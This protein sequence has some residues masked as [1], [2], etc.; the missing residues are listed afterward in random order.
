MAE[1]KTLQ[2]LDLDIGGFSDSITRSK[3]TLEE[4]S[5]KARGIG[6]KPVE[7]TE[8]LEEDSFFD[9]I[10]KL[11]RDN[12]YEPEQPSEDNTS[13]IRDN[14][15]SDYS[16]LVKSEVIQDVMKE[17]ITLGESP[18]KLE[19]IYT[20]MDTDFVT[21][22]NQPTV[23]SEGETLEIGQTE[24]LGLMS[25][26][27]GETLVDR[28]ESPSM[29][30]EAAPTEELSVDKKIL[31]PGFLNAIGITGSLTEKGVQAEVKKVL[32]EQG[33][34]DEDATSIIDNSISADEVQ[35]TDGKEEK[36]F[37]AIVG[38]ESENFNTIYGGSK[39]KTPKPIT[40]MTV[41]EVREWQ[42]DSVAAGSK[43]SAVGRFQIIRA[44]MDY[45]L[46][47]GI[48]KEDDSFNRITQLKA[49]E[50][51]MN[52]KL[53]FNSFKNSMSSATTDDEKLKLSEGFLLNI[54]KE[55]AAVPIPFDLPNR[56]NPLTGEG[57]KKGD[58]YYEGRSGNTTKHNKLK[59][60]DYIKILMRF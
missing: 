51:L 38:G 29:P 37:A 48:I 33:M 43:S 17:P 6:S 14:I 28:T 16:E 3:K 40:E 60:D 54:A 20:S 56:K 25:K 39:I 15:L 53:G 23:D 57:L 55:W 5:R 49:Y 35:P 2:G 27:F 46:S 9:N 4:V 59:T 19:D 10:V 7:E 50:G 26:P 58:S 8:E 18:N 22:E 41:E 24:S 11:F 42:D 32:K 44:N 21:L 31:S 47:Q 36:L 52:K 34:S 45:L 1:Y 13:T 30:D 12:G